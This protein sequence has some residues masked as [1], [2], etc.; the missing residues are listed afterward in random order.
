MSASYMQL[1]AMIFYKICYKTPESPYAIS[2]KNVCEGASVFR[3]NSCLLYT[4]IM[5]PFS[6]E[7]D[8]KG[9]IDNL[10]AN[11]EGLSFEECVIPVSYTHLDV[12]KRQGHK[13]FC[14]L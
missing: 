9:V 2:R 3:M 13:L 4:S 12:Y 5:V 8:I 14:S 11:M 6:V 7:L 1:C 10:K